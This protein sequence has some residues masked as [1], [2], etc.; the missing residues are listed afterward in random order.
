[1]VLSFFIAA[2]LVIF[3]GEGFK[4]A[5]SFTLFTQLLFYSPLFFFAFIML[6][7]PL[8]T[9]PTKKLRIIYGALCGVL[10]SPLIHIGSIYFTPE[11]S[12]VV[13]N[14]F[15]YIVS[16]KQKLMLKIKE[17]IKVA[18][19]TYDF[20]FT[21]GKN[22]SFKP[23]QYLEWTLKHTKSDSRGNR[24]Y[25]TIASSPT[26]KDLRVGV[27]FYP[28]GSS[29]KNGLSEMQAGDMIVAA[30]L[31][32][33]FVLPKDASKK[34]VFMAGGIGITPFRSQIKYLL[35]M[36]ERRDIV[37]FYSNRT[38]ADIAYKEIFDEAQTHI[39]LKTVYTITDVLP[40]GTV[41]E[42][43]TGYITAGII[44]DEVPDFLDR[45]FYL[46]GPHGMVAAFEK[47]LEDIGV[48]QSQ[49]KKDFFPGFA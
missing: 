25:F 49:I 28:N 30:Q 12:L 3:G 40:I 10:F 15:S 9:P 37:L 6:T 1:M 14:I 13:G 29:F 32:G 18:Q 19:D 45:Y 5:G 31:A 46:S 35:D 8:T 17:K 43:K 33:D 11:L 2:F 39:G 26:E 47:T 34:L 38:I 48:H 24:R 27:K 23:G 41:W 42:G 4:L 36:K 7:E 22:F 20:V 16:P 44:R 21:T